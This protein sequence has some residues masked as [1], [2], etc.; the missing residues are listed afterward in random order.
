MLESDDRESIR[1]DAS[2]NSNGIPAT[3]APLPILVGS[4]IH[5]KKRLHLKKEASVG[6]DWSRF[7]KRN[8]SVSIYVSS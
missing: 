8:E 1:D 6:L 4:V 5:K 7:G 3:W 2:A